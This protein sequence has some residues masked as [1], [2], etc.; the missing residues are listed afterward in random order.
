MGN[1]TDYYSRSVRKLSLLR[2][3]I[4]YERVR[5]ELSPGEVNRRVTAGAGIDASAADGFRRLLTRH[6]ETTAA[7]P[8]AAV[9]AGVAEPDAAGT[10]H[11]A[12]DWHLEERFGVAWPRR[13]VGAMSDHL[14]GSDVV[15]LWHKNKMMFLLGLVER[16]LATGERRYSD[17]WFAAVDSWCRQNPYMVGM[18]WRSPMETGTRLV[19]WSRSLAMLKGAPLPDES[20]CARITRSVVR[21]AEFLAGHFSAKA[22]PNNHLIGEAA[23]LYAFAAHWPILRDAGAWMDKGETILV[24]EAERQV[25][26]DGVQYE[27]SVNYHL[28]VL[29]FFLLYLATKAARGETPPTSVR[30]R[31]AALIDAALAMV[32]PAGRLPRI[33]DESI[34]EFLTITPEAWEAEGCGAEVTVAPLVRPCYAAALSAAAWG[35]PL[36]ERSA[37]LDR[38]RYFADAGIAVFRTPYSHLVFTGGP[39]HRRPFSPG[40]MH[41]DAGGFELE[42]GGVSVFIDS[43]TYLYSYDAALRDHFRSARAHNTVVVDGVEPATPKRRFA[44]QTVPEA[45]VTGVGAEGVVGFVACERDLPGR[46]GE[47]FVHRRVLVQ[48]GR[49][50]VVA[51][52]VSPAPGQPASPGHEAGVLFHTPLSPERVVARTRKVGLSLPGGAGE[53]YIDVFTTGEHAVEVL[54]GNRDPAGL[55]SRH[56]GNLCRG[57]TLRTSM[58]VGG[59][60]AFVHVVRDGATSVDSLRWEGSRVVVG[61]IGKGPREVVV[62]TKEARVSV[63]GAPIG[64]VD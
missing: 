48:L 34:S 60:C 19:V 46:D 20:V 31:A 53:W 39:Q 58:D 28:Y 41:A 37:P 1:L 2:D 50:W 32:S 33:G 26:P 25:L 8:M 5:P 35:R 63:D 17:E 16:Y 14:E 27:N 49:S 51:D 45:R 43:G 6:L 57:T 61:L 42:I 15:L 64:G 36:L 3:R 62:D 18:N 52:E 44:W 12:V 56:Y 11:H 9:G 4:T 55:Y 47:S 54:D 23:T 7:A 30:E 40:H 10:A 21:Q 24:D 22:V 38:A 13:F 59:G 29:D